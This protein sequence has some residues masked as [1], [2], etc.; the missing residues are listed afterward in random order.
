MNAAN[1]KDKRTKEQLLQIL[2]NALSQEEQLIEKIKMLENELAVCQK[3]NEESRT[4]ISQY[5]MSTSK[6]S[7]RIDYYK[8]GETGRLKGIIEHLPSRQK[9]SLKGLGIKHIASFMEGVLPE[10][11]GQEKPAARP[12]AAQAT[13]EKVQQKD[14]PQIENTE[15]VIRHQE[16]PATV[17]AAQTERTGADAAPSNLAQRLRQKIQSDLWKNEHWPLDFRELAL[18]PVETRA[19]S[20]VEQPLATAA[21][22]EEI[23]VLADHLPTDVSTA[24]ERSSRLIERLRSEFRSNLPNRVKAS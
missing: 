13:E 5:G 18:A 15:A 3:Q 7:F 6:E 21:A 2:S 1:N 10:S 20:V 14:L 11:A 16:A 22:P 24:S 8:T 17:K 23:S 9:K 4:D 12:M 19:A